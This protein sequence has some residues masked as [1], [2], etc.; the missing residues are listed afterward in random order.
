MALPYDIEADRI[1]VVQDETLLTFGDLDRRA[2]QIAQL[3][4]AH[5]VC[6]GDHVAFCLE[7]RVD[8]FSIVFGSI[9]AGVY[10]TAISPYLHA[11]EVAYIIENCG[12]KLVVGSEKT[13]QKMS[14]ARRTCQNVT[15]WYAMDGAIAGYES[16]DDA[17]A[18]QPAVLP[19]DPTEGIDMLYSSGSTGRPKGVLRPR[20]QI[21][22]GTENDNARPIFDLN[23][24]A[25]DTVYL[26][27]APL[28][29]AAPLRWTVGTLRRGG[30]VVNMGRFDAKTCL[31]LVAQH[32]VTHIQFVP[33]MMIRLLKLPE[34]AR[35]AAD[36]SSIRRI[37]HAAA[38]CPVETKKQFI[39]WWGPIIDEYYGG[40]ESNGL[41]YARCEDWLE[42][43]GTVGKAAL[44][45]IHI[46]GPDN[47]P[48]QAGQPGRVYFTGGM[49]FA[50]HGEPEKT[51]G[52]Y[53]G[54]MSTLGDI[55]YVN[56]AGF[57]FLTDRDVNLIISGGTNIYPQL[58]EDVLVQHPDVA[59]AA[60]IGVPDPDMGE[61]I[62][63][64][65]EPAAGSA[66][67]S[68]EQRLRDHA[69]YSLPTIRQP[70]HYDFVDVMARH[71]NGKLRKVEMQDA[72][73]KRFST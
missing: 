38:P 57:L 9:Y 26:N 61:V 69:A 70:R 30:R 2:K 17:M 44:G 39:D 31:D 11:G 32:R 58:T 29:H 4:R 15:A 36:L 33:T 46:I 23:G 49:K 3:I 6:P 59:D 68:L 21:A 66:R 12:A 67:S 45:V 24:I 71:P 1:A 52:A 47:Q 56:E 65:V 25:A 43:P 54:D 5:G 34:P 48:V 18:S 19:D 53:L 28:Y 14:E 73:R 40:T 22:F 63:A 8:F 20:P 16:L 64:V 51:K 42:N 35:S 72:Y 41:T 60:V 7:N 13:H 50:Y 27:P 37:V 62:M 10:Y 55:G